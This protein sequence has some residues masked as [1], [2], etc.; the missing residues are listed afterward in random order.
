M[1][2]Q[3][4]C[5]GMQPWAGYPSRDLKGRARAGV[6]CWWRPRVS[7]VQSSA[8]HAR[9][10]AAP[11]RSWG[12]VRLGESG[13][14]PQSSGV[15]GTSHWCRANPRPPLGHADHAPVT[16]ADDA[17]TLGPLAFQQQHICAGVTHRGGA[18]L[19][20]AGGVGARLHER[21]PSPAVPP[22]RSQRMAPEQ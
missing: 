1:C 5:Q 22:T 10:S 21:F 4:T 20:V 12:E 11:S 17:P 7:P 13:S 8:V 9:A 2:H 6:G 18:G 14:M 19:A 15:G 3:A 16:P